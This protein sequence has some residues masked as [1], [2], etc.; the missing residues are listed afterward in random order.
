MWSE[1]LRGY[2]ETGTV[3]KGID[4]IESS[5]DPSQPKLTLVDSLIQSVQ[6]QFTQ[7]GLRSDDYQVDRRQ[8]DLLRDVDK[9]KY[10]ELLNEARRASEDQRKAMR[11]ATLSQLK[12]IETYLDKF[13]PS[14]DRLRTYSNLA[15][16]FH[17][18]QDNEGTN[19]VLDQV[20]KDFSAMQASQ[21]IESSWLTSLKDWFR[22]FFHDRFAATACGLIVGLAFFL[23][24]TAQ[25]AAK[26]FSFK[27]YTWFDGP[28]IRKAL[29]ADDKSNEAE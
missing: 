4:L 2:A 8:L 11:A 25:T 9:V 14:D 6:F 12:T 28:N 18:L 13:P 24:P 3:Q 21:P 10:Q 5:N 22:P 1:V 23:R 16:V 26:A 20:Q 17:Q 19:R 29:K 7:P 27:F 15:K